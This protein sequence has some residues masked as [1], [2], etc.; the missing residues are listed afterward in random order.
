M[1]PNEAGRTVQELWGGRRGYTFP[2]PS[3]PRPQSAEEVWPWG[4]GCVSEDD[5]RVARMG[6][7]R[8]G[9]ILPAARSPYP[10][11]ELL[12]QRASVDRD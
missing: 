2:V 11:P 3:E 1:P 9:A 7:N 4:G 6:A 5:V 12:G 10:P 8:W